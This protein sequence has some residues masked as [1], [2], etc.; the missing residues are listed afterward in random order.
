MTGKFQSG[1][2]SF[3]CTEIGRCDL[4][5]FE[6]NPSPQK[7]TKRFGRLKKFT[8]LCKTNQKRLIYN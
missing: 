4:R 2:R 7:K 3:S 5:W 8:Y 1:K 6:S